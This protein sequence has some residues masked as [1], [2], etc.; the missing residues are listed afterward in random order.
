MPSPSSQGTLSPLLRVQ[1]DRGGGVHEAH[2]A[3]RHTLLLQGRLQPL[4]ARG[5]QGEYPAVRVGWPQGVE[6]KAMT[7]SVHLPEHPGVQPGST[8]TR[9]G[10]CTGAQWEAVGLA[11]YRGKEEPGPGSVSGEPGPRSLP[12][13]LKKLQN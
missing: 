13:A 3:R 2:G 10:L 1:G 5:L 4:R 11:G 8:C 6:L 9:A 12:P 7:G